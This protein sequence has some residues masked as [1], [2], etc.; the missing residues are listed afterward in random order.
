MNAQKRTI[1]SLAHS[2]N[3]PI[4]RDSTRNYQK[5]EYEGLKMW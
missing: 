1:S 3:L 2:T 5:V 4:N